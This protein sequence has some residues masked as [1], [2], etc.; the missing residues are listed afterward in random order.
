[1]PRVCLSAGLILSATVMLFIGFFPRATSSIMVMFVLLFFCGWLQ[2]MGWLT[3]GRSMVHWWS[4]KESGTIASIWNFA[5]NFGGGLA[6]LL[7][8]LE[9]VWFDD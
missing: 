5:H 2:G 3:C 6:P 7:F 9:M 8:L 1:N 4:K